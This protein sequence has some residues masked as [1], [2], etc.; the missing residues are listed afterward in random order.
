MPAATDERGICSG[1]QDCDGRWRRTPAE[2]KAAIVGCM[3]EPSGSAPVLVVRQGRTKRMPSPGVLRL[4]GGV[5]LSVTRMLPLRLPPGYHEF[6]A[7]SGGE[8]ITVIVTPGRCPLDE[9]MRIWGWAAQLYAARSRESCGIGDLADLRRLAT[10][11][12]S[13]GARVLLINPLFASA[14]V[15]TQQASPYYPSSRRYRNPLY[16]RIDEIPGA[17]PAGACAD[18]ARLLNQDRHIDRD[19]V[20]RVKMD[21]LWGIYRSGRRGAESTR[22]GP[23]RAADWTGSRPFVCSLS[24]TAAAGRRGPPGIAIRDLKRCAG[25]QPRRRSGSRFTAG[26]NGSSTG[27]SKPHRGRCPSCTIFR[28]ASIPGAPMPGSGRSSSRT[29]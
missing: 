14:P 24:G 18:T 17:L 28:S 10:W 9:G 15:P 4:E 5:E 25:S 19:L 20:F 22:T 26:C 8:M 21:A 3:G 1:Y 11:S 29:G 16:L 6:Y 27:N 12:A 13:L 7:D 2:T 23:E